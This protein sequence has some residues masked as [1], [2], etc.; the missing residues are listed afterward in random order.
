MIREPV[1]DTISAGKAAL[2]VV[3]ALATNKR[4]VLGQETVSDHSCE[5]D[6][7]PA[8]FERLAA[9]FRQ[10]PGRRGRLFPRPQ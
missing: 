10:C 7:I 1:T 4:L 5:Q 6:A 3:S 9:A 2:H 8:L